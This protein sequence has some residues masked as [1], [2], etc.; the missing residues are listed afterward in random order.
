MQERDAAKSRE[1]RIIRQKRGRA[2]ITDIA[3]R[4]CKMSGSQ[5]C[6]WLHG[7]GKCVRGMSRQLEGR[8]CKTEGCISVKTGE[9][10]FQQRTGVSSRK[11]LCCKLAR[12]ESKGY[13]LM[14]IEFFLLLP[15]EFYREVQIRSF[16]CV[17]LHHCPSYARGR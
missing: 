14:M 5:L 17:S 16:P 1:G 8:K 3:W 10:V 7:Q 2:F 12:A 9:E 11:Q 6:S 15:P 4:G 13:P